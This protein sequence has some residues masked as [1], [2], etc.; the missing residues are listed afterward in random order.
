[1]LVAFE[2][3]DGVGKSTVAK[4]V[5]KKINFR[6]EKQ[7][8]TNI[9]DI[10]DEVFNKLVKV[11]RTSE[12]EYMG[13]VFYTLRCMLDKDIKENTIVERSMISTY[14]FEHNKVS[15]E[16]FQKV[17]N[18]NLIPNITFILYASKDV[19]KER[20]YKR[21]I[22]DSDLKSDEALN[23]GYNTMLNFTREFNI[24]YVGIDTEKYSFEEIINICIETI[25]NY[26]LLSKE[27]QIKYLD[28]QNKIYGFEN[29]YD[30]GKVLKYEKI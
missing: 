7:R 2:G 21:N 3:M 4:A 5:A 6:H 1:M 17:M 8:L 29:K 12:N 23:D 15:K 26:K 16:E 25:I 28:E 19:R 13:F 22:N 18:Y 11:I 9:L 10:S 24:P 14:Y 30:C 27:E 20:I